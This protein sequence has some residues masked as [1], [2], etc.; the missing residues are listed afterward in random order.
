MLFLRYKFPRKVFFF[1]KKS[2]GFPC[3]LR[4]EP[5]LLPRLAR[6]QLITYILIM[7]PVWRIHELNWQGFYIENTHMT[8]SIE[9]E[10]QLIL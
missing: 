7:K 10:Y 2:S 8:K 4:E 3:W 1:V 6:L 5:K 9:P